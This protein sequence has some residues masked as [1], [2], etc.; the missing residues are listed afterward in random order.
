M[1]ALTSLVMTILHAVAASDRPSHLMMASSRFP[2]AHAAHKNYVIYHLKNKDSLNVN[3]II[4]LSI[5]VL[6]NEDG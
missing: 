3:D 4:S 1:S 6:L 2:A 5:S